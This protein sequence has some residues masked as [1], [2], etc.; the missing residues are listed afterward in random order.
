MSL[1]NQSLLAHLQRSQ[2]LNLL[3]AD[4]ASVSL[5]LED[6][7][8][9]S[10]RWIH[11]QIP[12]ANCRPYR[13]DVCFTT[14]GDATPSEI[15][16]ALGTPLQVSLPARGDSDVRVYSAH[17]NR[18]LDAGAHVSFSLV[19]VQQDTSPRSFG[20]LTSVSVTCPEEAPNAALKVLF[21]VQGGDEQE[22]VLS[23]G[24]PLHVFLNVGA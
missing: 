24:E 4:G 13:F 3:L 6:G 2:A 7:R 18:L 9:G 23:P 14:P 5:S 22:R 21:T 11:V 8:R 19:P 16:L 1:H 12:P 20:L 10:V 17:L 15:L